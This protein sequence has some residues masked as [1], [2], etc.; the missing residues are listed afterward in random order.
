MQR[1]PVAKRGL[2]NHQ[3]MM[4][5]LR[6]PLLRKTPC[7]SLVAAVNPS[8]MHA[9]AFVVQ[10]VSHKLEKECVVVFDVAHNI[11]QIMYWTSADGLWLNPNHHYCGLD[12]SA[13]NAS[14]CT[15]SA[16]QMVSHEHEKQDC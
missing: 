13:A 6:V 11:T 10:M 3:Y 16:L 7:A 8:A 4:I 1:V 2:H 12:F 15:V 9:N 14:T 5:D